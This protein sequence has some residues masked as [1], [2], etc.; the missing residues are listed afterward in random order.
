MAPRSE[1]KSDADDIIG[2]ECY[3]RKCCNRDLNHDDGD[4]QNVC[5]SSSTCCETTLAHVKDDLV[6]LRAKI[7]LTAHEEW[8]TVSYSQSPSWLKGTPYLLANHRPQLKS[9][10]V[11]FKSIFRWHTETL[12][13]WSHGLG[14]IFFGYLGWQFFGSLEHMPAT[15]SNVDWWMTFAW[16]FGQVC[17]CSLSTIYH[18]FNCH[19][20]HIGLS[21]VKCDYIGIFA[22][23]WSTLITAGYFCFYCDQMT[24]MAW[25]AVAGCVL[26]V[27]PFM[28]MTENNS[29]RCAIYAAVVCPNIIAFLSAL[30]ELIVFHPTL[31]W[32]SL[33]CLLGTYG[34]PSIGALIYLNKVPEKLCPGLFD[35][36]GH[37]HQLM[38]LLVLCCMYSQYELLLIATRLRFYGSCD[39]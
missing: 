14:A 7:T 38:H 27:G 28:V 23:C 22:S 29:Y 1:N 32:P 31:V 21:L 16:F 19:S 20:S 9:Y 17:C 8:S 37:S 2:Y 39:T 34:F 30:K 6:T 3:Q 13:I 11:A 36:I 10:R 26:I 18:T 35:L 24:R 25:Y 33:K 15:I 4:S 5:C 12:N